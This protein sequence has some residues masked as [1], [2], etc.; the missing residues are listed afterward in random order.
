[1]RLRWEFVSGPLNAGAF[2]PNQLDPTFGPEAVFVHAPPVPNTS[3]LDAAYQHFGEVQIDGR[4]AELTV[5]LCDATGAVLFA[6][7]LPAPGR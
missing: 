5:D 4:T 7:R 2:G 3:P 1:M 6:Q